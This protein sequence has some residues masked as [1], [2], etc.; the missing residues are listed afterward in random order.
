MN[1]GWLSLILAEILTRSIDS[2]ISLFKPSRILKD[3]A[4][5]IKAKELSPKIKKKKRSKRRVK[6]QGQKRFG[7]VP[8]AQLTVSC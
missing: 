2:F 6:A 3:V 1:G 5:T 7:S 4:I 8:H